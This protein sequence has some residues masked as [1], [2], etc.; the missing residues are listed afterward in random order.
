[1]ALLAA[2]KIAG[3]SGDHQ[4]FQVPKNLIAGHFWGWVFLTVGEYLHLRYLK[5]F[6]EVK[7]LDEFELSNISNH[8]TGV[9]PFGPRDLLDLDN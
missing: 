4:E 2:W 7:P 9:I 5:K 3:E 1:M 6:G 8:V